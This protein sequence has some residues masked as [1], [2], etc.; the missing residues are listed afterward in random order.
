M[1]LGAKRYYEDLVADPQR[2]QLAHSLAQSL[3]RLDA[4]PGDVEFRRRRYLA[5]PVYGFL[6]RG[7]D[8][9]ALVLWQPHPTNA[10][11]VVVRYLSPDI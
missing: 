6:V 1:I 7:G 11:D 3:V 9:E 8:E 10:D 2:W 5:R 4:D